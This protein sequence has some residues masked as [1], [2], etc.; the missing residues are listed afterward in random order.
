MIFISISYT[1][2]K[3]INKFSKMILKM[4]QKKMNKIFKMKKIKLRKIN[5]KQII[6][7]K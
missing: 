3:W 1:N 5:T 2:M 4:K 6:I 7:N